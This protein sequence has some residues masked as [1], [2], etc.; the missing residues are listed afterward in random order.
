MGNPVKLNVVITIGVILVY[1]VVTVLVMKQLVVLLMV[2]QR[3][4][5]IVKTNQIPVRG[6]SEGGERSVLYCSCCS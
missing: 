4:A 5:L 3:I 6:G 1:P 2:Y